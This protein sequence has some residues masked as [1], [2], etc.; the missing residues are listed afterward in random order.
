MFQNNE[1]IQENGKVLHI[2]CHFLHSLYS[3]T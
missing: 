2:V 3:A 1:Q